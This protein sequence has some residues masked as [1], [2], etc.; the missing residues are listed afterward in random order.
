[1][2]IAEAEKIVRSMGFINVRVRHVGEKARIEVDRPDV[3]VFFRC[4][5]S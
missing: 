2:R 5:K 1:M 4:V 3:A